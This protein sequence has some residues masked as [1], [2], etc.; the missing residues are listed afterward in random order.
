[1]KALTASSSLLTW[2]A[3]LVWLI[4]PEDRTVTV[5]RRDRAHRVLKAED[6]L[7]GED[8]LPALRC[9]VA[10]F[11]YMPGAEAFFRRSSQPAARRSFC[12]RLSLL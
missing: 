11:F 10:D 5:Y 4:D 8:I 7:T 9:R 6:E 3:A 1:V 2:G 12:G